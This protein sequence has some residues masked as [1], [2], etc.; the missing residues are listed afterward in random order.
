MLDTWY[1]YTICLVVLSIFFSLLLEAEVFPINFD[2]LCMNALFSL[3]VFNS[4]QSSQYS[5]RFSID[6][7]SLFMDI[8]FMLLFTLDEI[9]FKFEFWLFWIRLLG[10]GCFFLDN[11]FNF[12]KGDDTWVWLGVEWD[13]RRC[14][15]W[16]VWSSFTARQT[17][18]LLNCFFK[19]DATIKLM[20]WK[21][22]NL[23]LEE[24]C[25]QWLI[26]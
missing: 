18:M 25:L 9:K 8:R 13:L 4:S 12:F 6:S 16:W 21:L 3:S 14:F 26:K 11:L 2:S 15:S 24:V 7:L 23:I 1:F 17:L 22:L 5:S 19:K 20:Y 10:K